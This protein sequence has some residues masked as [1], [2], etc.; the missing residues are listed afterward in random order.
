MRISWE[1]LGFGFHPN[2]YFSV[3]LTAALV[4]ARLLSVE[5]IWQ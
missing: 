5:R 4:Q 1:E 2:A 3:L